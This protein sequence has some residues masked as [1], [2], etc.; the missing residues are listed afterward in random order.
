MPKRHLG[1]RPYQWSKSNQSCNHSFDCKLAIRPI[2]HPFWFSGLNPLPDGPL[3]YLPVSTCSSVLSLEAR[4]V[5]AEVLLEH[6]AA[7]QNRPFYEP[8]SYFLHVV[9]MVCVQAL[10]ISNRP[11]IVVEVCG[12]EILNKPTSNR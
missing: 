9:F 6:A 10:L 11:R 3:K 7:N 12:C 2:G 1:L 8:K 4:C 5:N